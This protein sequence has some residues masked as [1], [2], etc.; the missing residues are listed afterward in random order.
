MFDFQAN[1]Q[2]SEVRPRPVLALATSVAIHATVVLAALALTFSDGMIERPRP[3]RAMILLSPPPTL[4]T[5]HAVPLP[6]RR[7]DPTPLREFRVPAIRLAAAPLPEPAPIPIPV[8][9]IPLPEVPR[10]LLPPVEVAHLA[11]APLPPPQPLRIDNLAPLAAPPTATGSAMNRT[12]GALRS[13]GFEQTAMEASPHLRARRLTGE[14]F[15]DATLI[16]AVQPRHGSIAPALPV[17]RPV[18][19]LSKPRAAY[20]DDARRQRIEGE[21]LLQI[22]FAASGEVRVLGTVRGLGHGLDE[23]AIATAEAIRFRPAERAGIAADSTAIVH[24]VFQLAY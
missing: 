6:A 12:S 9:R 23:S 10:P 18:E 2:A 5:P 21:V 16:A 22:L 4:P 15:D 3:A 13:S 20:T 24:I 7:I 8:P 14:G 11:A 17:T 19:I 1:E